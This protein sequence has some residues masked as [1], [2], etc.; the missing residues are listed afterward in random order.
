MKGWLIIAA[1]VAILVGVHYAT[2]GHHY[3]AGSVSGGSGGFCSTHDCIGNFASGNGS[4]VQCSDGSWSHSG[5][6]QGCVLLARR[7][8]LQRFLVL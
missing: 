7:R 8:R 2:D 3:A 1:I 4:I 5:G 6:V